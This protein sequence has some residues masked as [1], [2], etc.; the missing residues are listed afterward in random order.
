MNR[1]KDIEEANKID[2][3]GKSQLGFKTKHSTLMAGLYFQ[4]LIARAVD[5]DSYV[6]TV[7]LDLSA[8]L[9]MGNFDF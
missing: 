5:G 4:F 2:L 9:D 6:L 7:S 8:V 3:S 1:I